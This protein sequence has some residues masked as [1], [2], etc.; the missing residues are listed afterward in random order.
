VVAIA[1]ACNEELGTGRDR[2]EHSSRG[3]HAGTSRWMGRW[4]RRAG[5]VA[6][7]TADVPSCGRLQRAFRLGGG[8]SH[9]LY[10]ASLP[11]SLLGC[12]CAAAVVFGMMAPKPSGQAGGGG[13][14]S[15]RG[16]PDGC[17]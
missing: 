8:P 13:G 11:V 7:R 2:A 4:H 15:W 10:V 6:A 16:G 1:R 5:A 9:G 3:S 17:R 12:R 14:L